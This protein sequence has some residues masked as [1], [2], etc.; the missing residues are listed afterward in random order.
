MLNNG[1]MLYSNENMKMENFEC[2]PNS[3]D[4]LMDAALVAMDTGDI[5]PLVKEELKLTIQSRRLA[6]G[7]GELQVQFEPPQQKELTEEEKEKVDRRR[8]QNRLAAQRFRQKQKLTGAQ[9][10]K[11]VRGLESDNTRLRRELKILQ[12]EREILRR[13]L[14]EHMKICPGQILHVINT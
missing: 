7:I 6:A 10:Q 14:E 8:E 11:K 2:L 5:T 3:Q 4:K 13:Q 9:V 12:T 1:L